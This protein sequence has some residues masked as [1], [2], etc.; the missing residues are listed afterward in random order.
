MLHRVHRTRYA[1]EA[2]NPT[3]QPD[4]LDGGR[5]DSL[6]GSYAY[7]YLGRTEEAAIAETICRDLPLNGSPRLAQWRDVVSRVL[8][9]VTVTRELTVL[10]LHGKHMSQV[11]APLELTKC[12]PGGYDVTRQWAHRLRLWL[13]DVAGFEYRPRHDE[14]DLAYVLFDDGPPP[15]AARARGALLSNGDSTSLDTGEGLIL[16]RRVLREH[17]AALDRRKRTP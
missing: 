17:N 16:A 13:P 5:F 9:S 12:D 3:A 10:K 7:T 2:F 4:K 14:D 8:T 11:H 1:A 15:A 6:D